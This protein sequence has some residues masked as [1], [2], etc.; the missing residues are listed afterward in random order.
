MKHQF[1]T[2]AGSV[3]GK[4]HLR[5][6]KNNQDSYSILNNYEKEIT[7]AVVCD[8][9]GS[10][11]HSEVGAK[12]GT[13]L[14]VNAINATWKN[15][16]LDDQFWQEVH[17]AIL[18]KLRNIITNLNEN[19][20]FLAIIDYYFLFTIVGAIIT[21]LE[22]VTFAIGDGI[23]AVNDEII[24]IDEFPD[25][26]PPYLAYKI[27]NPNSQKYDFQIYHRLPTAEVNSILIGTDG[28]KDLINNEQQNLPGKPEKVGHLSQFWQQDHYFKNSD[29]IRR[30]LSLI[31]QEITKPNWDNHTLEKT[32]GLLSDDTTL[33]AIRRIA[34]DNGNLS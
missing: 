31:N 1:E 21:P 9:C 22:T 25:N 17:Q 5:I 13:K 24:T 19:D 2:A 11:S 29:M 6:G 4:Y 26:A 8:G 27:C 20:G 34:N 18:E 32:P 7:I 10:C 15:Q 12:L 28:V 33:I 14:V 16:P 23:I 3:I 30:R